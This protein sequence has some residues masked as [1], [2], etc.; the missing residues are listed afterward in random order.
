MK[1]IEDRS[2]S[3]RWALVPLVFLAT[4]IFVHVF[5]TFASWFLSIFWGQDAEINVWIYQVLAGGVSSYYAIILSGSAAPKY[6]FATACIGSAVY[7]LIIF[8]LIYATFSKVGYLQPDL[9]WLILSTGIGIVIA[10][11]K[12]KD[13]FQI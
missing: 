9:K 7:S 2:P 4:A 11:V 10:M 8:W 13:R 1:W 3:T 12:A 5:I 6:K